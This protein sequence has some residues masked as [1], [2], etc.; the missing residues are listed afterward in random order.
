MNTHLSQN[1]DDRSRAT[2]NRNL[3]L[4]RVKH[5][6]LR[7]ENLKPGT[8]PVRPKL[9]ER[10]YLPRIRRVPRVAKSIYHRAKAHRGDSHHKYSIEHPGK[11]RHELDTFA[12]SSV[13]SVR[14]Q[15]LY[16][17]FGKFGTPTKNTPG[18]DIGLTYPTERRPCLNLLQPTPL[19][20]SIQ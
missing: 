13:S 9:S 4:S 1:L 17:Q 5:D 20:C 10:K 15:Y 8:R 12:D 6:F 7:V 19:L 16:P 11:V 3:G 18:T 2:Y 14:P